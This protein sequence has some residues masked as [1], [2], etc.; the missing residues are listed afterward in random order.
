MVVSYDGKFDIRDEFL[1]KDN[2]K[3]ILETLN[4]I[5]L[6]YEDL[7]VK[8]RLDKRDVMSYQILFSYLGTYPNIDIEFSHNYNE[9]E[10]SI[11]DVIDIYDSLKNRNR[12]DYVYV[13]VVHDNSLNVIK[14]KRNS[15]LKDLLEYLNVMSTNIVVNGKLKIENGNF[16][17]DESI[18]TVNVM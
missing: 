16:L 8:I 13:S 7:A 1:L 9:K 6:T 2:I 14:T 4:I 11:Y 5:D 10:I 3:E 15:N 17:I 18:N 12:R